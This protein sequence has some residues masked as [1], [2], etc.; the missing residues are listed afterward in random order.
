MTTLASGALDAATLITAID[1]DRRLA[2]EVLRKLPQMVTNDDDVVFEIDP[3]ISVPSFKK[4]GQQWS[5]TGGREIQARL[6]TTERNNIN[7]ISEIVRLGQAIGKSRINPSWNP[8][9]LTDSSDA[10]IANPLYRASVDYGMRFPAVAKSEKNPVYKNSGNGAIIGNWLLPNHTQKVIERTLVN[11]ATTAAAI[12]LSYNQLFNRQITELQTYSVYHPPYTQTYGGYYTWQ[13]YY[14]SV[15]GDTKTDL[16][17]RT[18]VPSY[19][20]TYGGYYSTHTQQVTKFVKPQILS[21]DGEYAFVGQTFYCTNAQVLLG[22]TL[23]VTNYTTTNAAAAPKYL[24]VRTE[25]GK[26]VLN[27]VIATGTANATG[28]KYS[29]SEEIQVLWDKPVYLAAKEQLAIVVGFKANFELGCNSETDRTGALFVCQDHYFWSEYE[30]VSSS[31]ISSNKYDLRYNLIVADFT[32]ASKVMELQPLELSGGISSAKLSL[33]TQNEGSDM[34]N[35][36]FEVQHNSLWYPLS[37]LDKN[38]DL[39]PF[40]PFR[41]TVKGT[42]DVMPLIHKTDTTIT[43][44]RPDAT[45]RFLSKTRK[46]Q[47]PNIKIVYELAGFNPV[48]HEASLKLL[49]DGQLYEPVIATSSTSEGG[50]VRTVRCEFAL[51]LN[52]SEYQI[53]IEAT[54]KNASIMFDVTSV[55][56]LI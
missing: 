23:Q 10:D 37:L 35:V 54:T 31:Y 46:K 56:E 18:Y 34:D 44:L 42:N 28:V 1:K 29:T 22:V 15:N 19:S 13:R 3:T 4:M 39:P 41:V 47:A 43:L 55:I 6:D 26:P 49:A 51:P 8:L 20:V 32:N 9:N 16:S 45:M 36:L 7:I 27:D 30:A 17:R 5:E 21:M 38:V 40:V 24:L 2:A 12:R 11:P 53:Q 25:N 48:L 50:L 33:V 14:T 52:I